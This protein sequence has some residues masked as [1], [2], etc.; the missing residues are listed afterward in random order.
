MLEAANRILAYI[1]S[2][3]RVSLRNT[4]IRSNAHPNICR[5]GMDS[6]SNSSRPGDE[7]P[8]VASRSGRPRGEGGLVC[9]ARDKCENALFIGVLAMLTGMSISFLSLL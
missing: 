8:D 1:K 7:S 3:V 6:L 4:R 2:V 5:L 9:Y